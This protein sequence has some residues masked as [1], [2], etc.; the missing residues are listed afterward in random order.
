MVKVFDRLDRLVRQG[1]MSIRLSNEALT[2]FEKLRK[3]VHK[4]V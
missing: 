4:K 3:Q 1:N 2:E